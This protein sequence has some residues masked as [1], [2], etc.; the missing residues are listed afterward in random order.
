VQAVELVEHR[1][2]L[3]A[4]RRFAGQAESITRVPLVE[5]GTLSRRHP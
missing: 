2:A 1:I 5:P 4:R 3:L